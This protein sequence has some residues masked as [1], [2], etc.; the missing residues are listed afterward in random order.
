MFAFTYR[1]TRHYLFGLAISSWIKL[2]TFGL[3]LLVWIQKWN[4]FFL[5]LIIF[6]FV[7]VWLNYRIARR[8]GFTKFIFQPTELVPSS[9]LKP[10]PANQHVDVLATGIFTVHNWNEYVLLHPAGYW[11]VPLGDHVVMV[12]VG[13]QRFL[14][15]FFN[16]ECLQD[17]QSGWLLFGTR[18]RKTLA[19]TFHETHFAI[20]PKQFNFSNPADTGNT[21]GPK[22]T[23]YFTFD[24]EEVHR[25]IWHTILADA[26]RIRA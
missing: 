4:S 24:D 9:E 10:I 26:R 15:Q 18:L 17:I 7:W 16:A 3:M 12:K 6:L 5:G 22:R 1:T 21:I 11:Q 20:S 14:Y 19:I 25:A 8:A 13:R 23:I 2:I